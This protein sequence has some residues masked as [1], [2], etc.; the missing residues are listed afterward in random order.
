[1][2]TGHE[3]RLEK[4]KSML[5]RM[6]ADA[7]AGRSVYIN[8]VHEFFAALPQTHSDRIVLAIEELG[9]EGKKA[10][11]LR[12][13][14]L[15]GCDAAEKAFVREYLYAEA[16][17]ILSSIGGRSMTVFVD[18]GNSEVLDLASSLNEAF[19]V[20]LPRNRRKGYGR[21]INVLDRMIAAVRPGEPPFRFFVDDVST[22]PTNSRP[23]NV[24]MASRVRAMG[25]SISAFLRCAADLEGKAFCGI[26]VG[27]TDIKAVV[28]D[29]GRV[30]DYKEYDWFPAGFLRSR[31]LVDPICL[32]ARLLRARLW[33]HRASVSD[34]RRKVLLER[35]AVAMHKDA[36]DAAIERA[37]VAL[38]EEGLDEALRFDAIGLCFPDVVVKDKIVGGEVYKTRGIRNNPDL[39]Y[40]A[41]FSEL[42]GLDERLKEWVKPGG[43]VRIINDGPMASFT[44]AVEIAASSEAGKVAKGVFAHTLGTELGTGWVTGAGTIPDIPLEVY[45]FI[46]DLGSWPERAYE[47]DDL[48]SVNNF[49]TGLPGTLQKY[50]SQSGVFRLALKYFPDERADL[51]R[52]LEEKGYVVRRTTGGSTGWYVPTEPVDQRKPF[53]EHMMTLPDRERDETNRKIWREIG[54]ALAVTLLETKRILDPGTDERFLFGRLVKNRA[55]FDLL[56]EGARGVEPGIRLSVAGTGMANTPLM[57]QLEGHPDFTVA[58]FAQAIGAVYFA[59]ER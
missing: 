59:N 46:I 34:E 55:C 47:P 42:T 36:N 29:D 49:N 23:H 44:A 52:E 19:C 37:L 32:I 28:V 15:D 2:S 51:L 4:E 11:E 1:M 50:C 40:E 38:G 22:W 54:A 21:A 56:A 58:Q 48:R 30:V 17:N 7:G 24:P 9:A 25:D 16:Y 53:L 5:E 31:Q 13:P 8:R 35:I 33:I 12:I 20:S 43:R 45:N 39:D 3:R 10:W 41:D 26:D 27:G 14:K 57:K 18:R 6:I